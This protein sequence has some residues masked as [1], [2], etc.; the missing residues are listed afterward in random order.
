MADHLRLG[1]DLGSTTAKEVLVGPDGNVIHENYGRHNADNRATLSRDL[2]SMVTGNLVTPDQMVTVA[3]TGTGAKVLAEQ[4]GV[5]FTQELKATEA[6]FRNSFFPGVTTYIELGGEDSKI[7]RVTYDEEGDLVRIDPTMNLTCAAGTGS[8]IEQ[9]A[10]RMGTDVAGLNQLAREWPDDGELLPTGYRCGVFLRNAIQESSNLGYSLPQLAKSAFYGVAGQTMQLA[11]GTP[12]DGRRVQMAGGALYYSPELSRA[13]EEIISMQSPGAEIVRPTEEALYYPALGAALGSST[14]IAFGALQ[15]RLAESIN[16]RGSYDQLPPIFAGPEDRAA[17][18]ERHN[19]DV[20]AERSDEFTPKLF[21]G[22]DAGSTTIKIV[23]LNKRGQI[24][25]DSYFSNKADIKTALANV[26]ADLYEVI[27]DSSHITYTVATGYGGEDIAVRAF[28][29][30]EYVV[31]MSAHHKAA[32]TLAP[33]VGCVVDVGGKD[34]KVMMC[35]ENGY[36]TRKNEIC[37]SGSGSFLE[38]AATLLFGKSVKEISEMALNAQHPAS[39]NERCTILFTSAMRGLL[40]K[41][42]PAEDIAA[43]LICGLARNIAR[44][45]VHAGAKFQEAL[46]GRPI[47]VQ[48]GTFLNDALLAAFENQL[49]MPVI[50]PSGGLSGIMGAYGAAVM[51]MEKGTE[52]D[53]RSSLLPATELGGVE[54]S[55]D[56]VASIR[57]RIDPSLPDLFNLNYQLLFDRDMEPKGPNQRGTVGIPRALDMYKN[58]PLFCEAFTRLGFRVVLS[59]ESN[60]K[61]QLESAHTI[62]GDNDCFPE[63]LSHSHVIELA[64]SDVDFVFMPSCRWGRPPFAGM[65]D[66]YSCPLVSGTP[67]RIADNIHEVRT[68]E[69]P[70]LNPSMSLLDKKEFA[71]ELRETLKGQGYRLSKKEIGAAVE[72][73]WQEQDRFEADLKQ[74]GEDALQSLRDS[75]K[76]AIVL[77][78]RPYQIDPLVH[79]LAPDIIR[80]MGYGVLTADSISHLADPPQLNVRDQWALPTHLYRAASAVCKYPDQLEFVHLSSMGCGPDIVAEIELER[81]LSAHGKK[82]TFLRLDEQDGFG[83]I[84]LSMGALID[85]MKDPRP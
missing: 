57:E 63:K 1:I 77:A 18:L 56:H 30:D 39:V 49:G 65:R 20:T 7:V 69:I 28:K 62:L 74:A 45:E 22:I 78:C 52:S 17:F 16:I 67:I 40:Q 34:V 35:D 8:I 47:L 75:G 4:I 72:Y 12:I 21:L 42:V 85:S 32:K 66:S 15:A 55:I 14:T 83:A 81:I 9:V 58:F 51:A 73:A 5:P 41:N 54:I 71:R 23:L 70:F 25:H 24:V 26:L 19:S 46:E 59:S 68:S 3:M 79:H 53:H 43:G 6:L 84:K 38:D 48:G 61:A 27:P 64:K 37:S 76:R 29:A 80:S 2:A 44:R 10:S 36:T 13:F 33:D 82:Y 60:E 31:E 50:R 11:K